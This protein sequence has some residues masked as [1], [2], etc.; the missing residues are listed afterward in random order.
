[1]LAF[2]AGSDSIVNENLA[3]RFMM[4]ADPRPKAFYGFQSGEHPQQDV[5]ALIDTAVK[6]PRQTRLNAVNGSRYQEEGRL[7]AAVDRRRVGDVR[8]NAASRSHSRASSSPAF[9]SIFW[10]SNRLLLSLCFFQ[11]A[12]LAE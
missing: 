12:H 4:V 9:C 11:R 2:F 8:G 10:M 3:N 1:V 5:R 6:T 7:G